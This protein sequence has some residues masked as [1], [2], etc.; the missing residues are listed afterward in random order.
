[1]AE[2]GKRWSEEW[3]GGCDGLSRRYG[4]GKARWRWRSPWREQERKKSESESRQ[5]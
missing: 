4:V 3:R 5:M 2:L 1:M